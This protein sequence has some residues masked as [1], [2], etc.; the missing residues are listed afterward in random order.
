MDDRHFI[1]IVQ[2]ALIQRRQSFAK[3]YFS[4]A[5]E[6]LA[7][8]S[9]NEKNKTK[10]RNFLTGFV[11]DKNRRTKAAA[12]SALGTLGDPKAIPVI[13]SFE[14]D[15]HPDRIQRAA[16]RALGKLREQ[17]PLVP[18]E[19]NELRRIFDELKKDNEKLRTEFEDL[20]KRIDAKD[21]QNEASD[22]K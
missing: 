8:I 9:R 13:Q 16:A 21:Q 4:G 3:S 11:N 6:T 10:V 14:G 15:D 1:G 22:D 5:L 20:K 2:K 7:K 12:I 18:A 19:I 17:K